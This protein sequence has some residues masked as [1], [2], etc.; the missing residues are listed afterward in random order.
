MVVRNEEKRWSKSC[1]FTKEKDSVHSSV[2][3]HFR[4]TNG[5]YAFSTNFAEYDF[6]KNEFGMQIQMS[7]SVTSVRRPKMKRDAGVN[8]VF[9]LS[10]KTAFTPASLFIFGRPT[11]V[12][13]LIALP[14]RSQ[15]RCDVCF[16]RIFVI[17]KY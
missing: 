15:K 1:L 8:A 6:F 17:R 7:K 9:F 13:A 10:K 5:R 14:L 12:M 11:D 3:L 16:R 4:A 2:S